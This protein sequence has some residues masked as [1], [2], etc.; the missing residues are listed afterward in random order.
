M[1]KKIK[2]LNTGNF[3]PQ[4]TLLLSFASFY[5]Y[6]LVPAVST[7][8]FSHFALTWIF[9]LVGSLIHCVNQTL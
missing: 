2:N 8:K 1:Q 4:T 5:S 7:K 6:T 9:N 3:N